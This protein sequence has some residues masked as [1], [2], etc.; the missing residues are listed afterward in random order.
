MSP[1]EK[2]KSD[3]LIQGSEDA[4]SEEAG[5][6]VTFGSQANMTKEIDNDFRQMKQNEVSYD[7]QHFIEKTEEQ[8]SSPL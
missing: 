7:K 3:R 8:E 1:S 5:S 2:P 6:V 4:G